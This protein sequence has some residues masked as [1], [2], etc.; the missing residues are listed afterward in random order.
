MKF[1]RLR[2]PSYHAGPNLTP[3]VDV[4][5][6]VLIFLMLAGSFGCA[7]H[8]LK[9]RAADGGSAPSSAP[10]PAPTVL[11]EMIDV[12][13]WRGPG[14]A[15]AAQAGDVRAG[16]AASLGTGLAEKRRLYE[17][18]GTPAEDIRVVIRPAADVPYEHVAAA[19]EAVLKAGYEHVAFATSE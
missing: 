1:N 9:A 15:F 3:L 11:P 12:V 7:Q 18:N 14:G 4:V 17:A 10:P 19:F 6:V 8:F 2:P 16:A 5:M 13:M